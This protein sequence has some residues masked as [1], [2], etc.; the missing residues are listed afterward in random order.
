MKTF[1]ILLLA[2]P[3]IASGPKFIGTKTDSPIYQEFNNVYGDIRNP[4]INYAQITSATI[5]NATI[6]NLSGSGAGKLVQSSFTI[7][8]ANTNTNG[9]TFIFV[10][11]SSITITP[12]SV[13]DRVLVKGQ[14]EILVNDDAGQ[15]AIARVAIFRNGVSVFDSIRSAGNATTT[16]IG[17]YFVVPILFLDTP[18]T[19]SATTWDI[20]FSRNSSFGTGTIFINDGGGSSSFGVQEIQL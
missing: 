4:V 19:T 20:R 18:A 7:I 3:C 11:G 8:N 5:T 6:T 10:A 12:T 13:N 1:F 2:A 17:M 14:L 15:A 9:T 16:G